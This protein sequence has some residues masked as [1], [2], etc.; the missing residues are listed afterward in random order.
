MPEYNP[1]KIARQIPP[2]PDRSELVSTPYQQAFFIDKQDSNW[3]DGIR[4]FLIANFRHHNPLKYINA[5]IQELAALENLSS[6]H[7]DTPKS[8]QKSLRPEI[9]MEINSESIVVNYWV[10]NA[11]PKKFTVDRLYFLRRVNANSE[12]N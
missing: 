5:V 10:E 6:S 3:E 8:K 12:S 9:R 4:A 7:Q 2:Q 1:G 11:K